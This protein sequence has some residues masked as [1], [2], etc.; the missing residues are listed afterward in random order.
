MT[1][2]ETIHRISFLEREY[3]RRKLVLDESGTVEKTRGE[4]IETDPKHDP[5]Y[6]CDC[7]AVLDNE[8][9]AKD[10]LLEKQS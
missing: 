4:F 9:D 8:D 1:D 5:E 3:R 2:G 6:A 7:G 10:H